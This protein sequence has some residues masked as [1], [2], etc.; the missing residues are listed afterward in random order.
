MSQENVEM[1][2]GWIDAWDRG[3]RSLPDDEIDP[4][5]VIESRL[6]PEP[7]AGLEGLAQW[8]REIDE[9]FQEWRIAV[10]DWRSTGNLVVAL[11]NLN[12]RGRASGVAFDEPAAAVVEVNDRRLSRLRFF[13]DR[14]E[15]LEAAGLRE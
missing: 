13:A 15:A 7:Y 12:I 8:M 1:V 3:E 14:A 9:Q 2:K 5:V 10:N 6:R 4:D 11:G